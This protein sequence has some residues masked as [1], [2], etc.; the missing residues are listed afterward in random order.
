ML[1][2][3]RCARILDACAHRFRVSQIYPKSVARAFSVMQ[4]ALLPSLWHRRTCGTTFLQRKIGSLSGTRSVEPMTQK[5]PPVLRGLRLLLACLPAFCAAAYGAFLTG[6]DLV[7][8]LHS[9][10]RVILMRHTSSP[11]TPQRIQYTSRPIPRLPAPG[12]VC[13]SVMGYAAR[14]PAPG[15]RFASREPLWTR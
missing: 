14:S 11:R 4:R 9:G 15:R 1:A 10:G 8:T 6:R 7:T 2:R 3:P 5:S 13:G 12:C